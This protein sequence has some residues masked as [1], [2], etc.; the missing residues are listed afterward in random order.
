M[1]LKAETPYQQR[2]KRPQAQVL[3]QRSSSQRGNENLQDDATRNLA[4]RLSL[5]PELEVQY[6][7]YFQQ[8]HGSLLAA[9]IPA[10]LRMAQGIIYE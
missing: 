3:I 6:H 2:N 9:S 5:M 7:E 10:A 4:K 8:T 1:I